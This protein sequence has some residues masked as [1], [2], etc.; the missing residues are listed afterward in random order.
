MSIKGE[1]VHY[2]E[3]SDQILMIGIRKSHPI[4]TKMFCFLQSRGLKSTVL[5]YLLR[6]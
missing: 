4:S 6:G 2:F 5:H 3:M 1:K